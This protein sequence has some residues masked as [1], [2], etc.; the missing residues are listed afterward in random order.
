MGS[1][2]ER[3]DKAAAK[4]KTSRFKVKRSRASRNRSRCSKS[5]LHSSKHDGV[6]SPGINSSCLSN[7][8]RRSK[9]RKNQTLGDT[10]PRSIGRK[11]MQ[12]TAVIRTKENSPARRG[13]KSQKELVTSV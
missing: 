13:D 5:P 2:L 10:S 6:M 7:G 1:E 11:F 4:S 12:N 9:P 8:S 3:L